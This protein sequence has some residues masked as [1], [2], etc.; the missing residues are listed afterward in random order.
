MA[1]VC[2]LAGSINSVI[3]TSLS[4]PCSLSAFKIIADCIFL[5]LNNK[6]KK[7]INKNIDIAKQ[8]MNKGMTK[9]AYSFICSIVLHT[10][11]PIKNPTPNTAQ[12]VAAIGKTLLVLLYCFSNSIWKI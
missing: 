10:K 4:S 3:G 5:L 1:P 9:P 7:I 12:M 8:I 2:S 11:Y 6:V